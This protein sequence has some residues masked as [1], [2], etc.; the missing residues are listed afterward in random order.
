MNVFGFFFYIND[1]GVITPSRLS[2]FNMSERRQDENVAGISKR[3][4]AN[5][6]I[7]Y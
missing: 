4:D 7:F 1:L 6:D 2:S 3:R 5:F